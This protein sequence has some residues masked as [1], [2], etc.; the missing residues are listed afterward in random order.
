MK[1]SKRQDIESDTAY[2]VWR[3]ETAEKRYEFATGTFIVRNGKIV[4]QTFA[5]KVSPK[6][7]PR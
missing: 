5:G 1:R 2:L 6:L 7:L 3:A 4:T